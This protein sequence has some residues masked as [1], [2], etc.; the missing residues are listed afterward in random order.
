M[1]RSR[2]LSIKIE[3]ANKLKSSLLKLKQLCPEPWNTANPLLFIRLLPIGWL[4]EGFSHI[5]S[6]IF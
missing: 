1:N 3:S 6:T 4:F 2:Y 5:F